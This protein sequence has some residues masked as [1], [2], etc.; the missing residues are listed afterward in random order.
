[1]IKTMTSPAERKSAGDGGQQAIPLDDTEGG[2]PA[3]P[4]TFYSYCLTEDS[5]GVGKKKKEQDTHHIDGRNILGRK[6][7][8]KR[9]GG[10]GGGG[11]GVV[12]ADASHERDLCRH[13]DA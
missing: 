10:G 4:A 3:S 5:S 6:V 9:G 12:C 8:R 1:M 11:G 2:Y 13:S 7:K